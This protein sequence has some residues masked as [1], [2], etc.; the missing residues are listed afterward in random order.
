[1]TM[2]VIIIIMTYHHM[3]KKETRVSPVLPRRK[4]DICKEER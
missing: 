4:P 2:M 3:S 1:M